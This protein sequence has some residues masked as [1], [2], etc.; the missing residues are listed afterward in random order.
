MSDH[1]ALAPEAPGPWGHRLWATWYARWMLSVFSTAL[2][3]GLL[4][5]FY[6]VVRQA[7]VES[8]LHQQAL[9]VHAQG[10]WR[11]KQLPNASARQDC[12]LAVPKLLANGDIAT[13]QVSR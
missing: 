10:T 9:A 11:C 7:A 3:G 1:P 12:L 4:L 2:V 5:A 6:N 8:A 13:A